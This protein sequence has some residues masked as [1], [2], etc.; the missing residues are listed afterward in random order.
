MNHG[1]ATLH[2]GN[3]RSFHVGGK[4]VSP[5]KFNHSTQVGGGLEGGT[6]NIPNEEAQAV[7]GGD[8]FWDKRAAQN[9][10]GSSDENLHRAEPRAMFPPVEEEKD[11]NGAPEVRQLSGAWNS[12]ADERKSKRDDARSMNAL[13]KGNWKV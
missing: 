13:Q 5:V 12:P 2:H 6:R 10:G 8:E 3:K 1:V 7:S 9:A 4:E 11:L